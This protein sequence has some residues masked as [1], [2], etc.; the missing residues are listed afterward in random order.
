[1]SNVFEVEKYNQEVIR[2]NEL[3]NAFAD[4]FTNQRQSS[5]LE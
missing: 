5:H 3:R 2:I 4:S 1:M